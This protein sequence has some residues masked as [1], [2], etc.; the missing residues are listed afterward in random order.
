[1]SVCRLTRLLTLAVGTHWALSGWSLGIWV[2]RVDKVFSCAA[3][4]SAGR[5]WKE[6]DSPLHEGLFSCSDRIKDCYIEWKWSCGMFPGGPPWCRRWGCN[7]PTPP[8]LQLLPNSKFRL[9]LTQILR[10]YKRAKGVDYSVHLLRICFGKHN[11][12]FIVHIS[13]AAGNWAH[14]ASGSCE[15]QFMA[16]GN[17]CKEINWLLN[18]AECLLHGGARAKGGKSYSE[19]VAK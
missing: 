19:V 1:M 3:G 2:G 5:A 18:R 16:G 7:T 14:A 13:I 10:V 4:N 15:T 11:T 12:Y 6:A 8:P 17:S 9:C